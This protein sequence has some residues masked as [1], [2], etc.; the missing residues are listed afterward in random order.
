MSDE[1]R[2]ECFRLARALAE[3][4]HALNADCYIPVLVEDEMYEITAKWRQVVPCSE[5]STAGSE[6]TPLDDQIEAV[7]EALNSLIQSQRDL[8]RIPASV[9][10]QIDGLRATL[11]TL[12]KAAQTDRYEEPDDLW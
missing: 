9:D 11:T 6:L 1:L 8:N 5:P 2:E 12:A 4:L 3:K 10:R 7:S